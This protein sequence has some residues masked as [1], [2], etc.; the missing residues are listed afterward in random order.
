MAELDLMGQVPMAAAVAVQ[1]VLV[2]MP[3]PLFV[4]RLAQELRQVF[5]VAP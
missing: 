5:Q 4:V 2:A 1:V 3:Q